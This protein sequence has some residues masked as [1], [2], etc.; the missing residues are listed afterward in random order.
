MVIELVGP[1]AAGKTSLLAALGGSRAGL[2]AGLRV[3]R[4]HHVLTAIGLAPTLLAL[5]LPC[6]GLHWKTMKRITYLGTLHRLVREPA[7]LGAGTVILDEGAVYMLARLQ[8]YG[9]DR[10]RSRAYP[11]WWLEAIQGWAR[12]LDLIVWLDAPDPV[13]RHRLRERRQTHPA[14]HLSDEAVSSFLACYRDAYWR[15]IS[16]LTALEGPRV[17]TIRT[18]EAS[19]EDVVGRVVAEMRAIDGVGQ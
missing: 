7:W 6:D 13:L 12:T 10:I 9:A 17:L 4:H 11:R 1:A 14:K 8:V 5:H 3:P 19:V 16:T 2:R 18:D 15:V